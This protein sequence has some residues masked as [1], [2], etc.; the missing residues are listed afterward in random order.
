MRPFPSIS[1]LFSRYP[2]SGSAPQLQGLPNQMKRVKLGMEGDKPLLSD[3]V[4]ENDLTR[5]QILTRLGDLTREVEEA[6]NNPSDIAALS[7]LTEERDELRTTLRS[8][9]P[10]SLDGMRRELAGLRVH[11]EQFRGQ[12]VGR[13]L[14]QDSAE[15][16]SSAVDAVADLQGSADPHSAVAWILQRI[17]FIEDQIA[18]N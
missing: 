7:A 14:G 8:H 2:S 5:D 9:A 18:R 6:R 15:G 12:G 13:A 4:K 3:K 10:L 17:A 16:T 1:N 11:L